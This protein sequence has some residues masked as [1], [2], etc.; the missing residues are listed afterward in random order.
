MDLPS[1]VFLGASLLFVS[2]PALRLVRL[3]PWHVAA[4]A[5]GTLAVFGQLETE[6]VLYVAQRLSP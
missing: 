6:R 5:T 1:I 4:L 3:K 2:A